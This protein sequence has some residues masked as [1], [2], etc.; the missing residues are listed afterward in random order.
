MGI[1][2]EDMTNKQ[3]YREFCKIEKNIPIFSKDW[4][5]DSV[6]GEDNW[7]VALV[8]KGSKIIASMPFFETRKFFLKMILMPKLTKTMGPYIIYPERQRYQEKLSYEKD[9]MNK[10]IDQLPDVDFFFQHFHYSITNWLPYYWRGFKQTTRYTY[11]IEDLS[12]LNDVFSNFSYSKRKNIKRAE[13]LLTVK[14]DLP[15]KNFYEHHKMTLA[16]QNKFI[17]YSYSLFK[18]IYDSGYMHNSARTIYAEDGQGNIHSALFIIWD[19]NSAYDLISTIDPDFRNSG[20]ASLL[21]R[22]A[23][24]MVSTVTKK[25]DFEGSMEESVENSFRQ[26]GAVQKPYFRIIKFKNKFIKLLYDVYKE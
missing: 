2:S 8:E 9:I 4:W 11:V 10:L 17:N 15:A 3:K 18:R 7:D 16:K 20:S 13:D 21:I 26:F 25:F 6:C 12:N 24:K 1:I 14:F 19:D 22:E 5:L 23:I